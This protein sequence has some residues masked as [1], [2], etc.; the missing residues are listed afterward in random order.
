[1]ADLILGQDWLRPVH[2]LLGRP[3]GSGPTDRRTIVGA[4]A[5][6]AWAIPDAQFLTQIGDDARTVTYAEAYRAVMQEAGFLVASGLARG[7][8]VGVLGQNSIDFALA[9]LAILEAGGVVV[10]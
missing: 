9:V 3:F 2:H 8:R 6:Q 4:L 10:P 7:D 5:R 1:M